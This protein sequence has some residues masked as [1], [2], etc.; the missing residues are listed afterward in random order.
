MT[1]DPKNPDLSRAT[2][3]PWDKDGAL[4]IPSGAPKARR[5]GASSK[6]GAAEPEPAPADGHRPPAREEY[7]GPQTAS[8]GEHVEPGDAG[9]SGPRGR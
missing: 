6:R 5:A 9:S 7:P 1:R 8:T 2:H 3:L 4:P